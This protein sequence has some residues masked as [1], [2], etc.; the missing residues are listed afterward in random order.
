MRY[1]LRHALRLMLRRPGVAALVVTTLAIGI[2]AT[3]VVFSLAD[4]ILWHP[5]P[6]SDAERFVRVRVAF[7]APPSSGAPLDLDS[8]LFDGVYP[9]QLNSAIVKVAGE[10]RAVT[11]GEI[12]QGLVHTLGAL[13]M[14]G[15]E[16]APDEFVADSRVVIVSA[17]LW[18]QQRAAKSPDDHTLSIDGVSHTIVGVMPD[19]FEFPVSRV[20][21]WRPLVPD[22]S[23]AR[24]TGL[25]RLKPGVT[26]G[27]AQAFAQAARTTRGSP[28]SDIR[29]VPFVFVIPSTATALRILLGAVALLLLIAVANAANIIQAETVRRDTELAVRAS[30]GAS[31]LRLVRQLITEA[32]LISI[33][34]A[35]VAVVVSAWTLAAL[36]KAVPYLMSFQALRPIG[37]DWRALVFA[38]G[39]SLVAGIGASWLSAIRARR[40]DPQMALRGH[41]SG[42]PGQARAREI[43]TAA[44][45][46]VTLILLCGAGLL[47]NGFLRLSRVDP[48]FDPSHLI[49]VE[50]QLPTWRYSGEPDMR[51]ALDRLRTETMRLPGVEGV[52]IAHSM[53][54]NLES[55]PL[56]GLVTDDTTLAP[57]TGYVSTG[58]VDDRFF[59]TLG[60][61][62]LAGRAFD[63]RDQQNSPPVAVVSR[64]FAQQLWPGR[65]PLGR[66][67]RESATTLWHTIVGIVGDV[68]N[69]GFDQP[70]GP[71]AY[72]TARNQSPTWWYEGLI[73]RTRSTPERMVP[74]L[75]SVI[76]RA[77]P[78]APVV[79]V[80]TGYDTIAGANARVRFA[81][82]LMITFAAI[83]LAV[84]LIGIYGT[85]WC[86]VSQR[87]REIG[88][89]MALGATSPDVLRMVLAGSI[90]LVA[91]GLALGLPLSLATSQV[92]KSLLFEVSPT[93]PTTFVAVIAFLAAAAMA[94]TFFPA[95]RAAAVD[96]VE[97]LRTQ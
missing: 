62:L 11:V 57:N 45:I 72:Y 21:L 49:D 76:Q 19:G 46:A 38:T 51:A 25:G 85:F 7:V 68:R 58:I 15:R 93:D 94:A 30:L 12:S 71:L 39:I 8:S 40:M 3:T 82:L 31:W 91:I 88:V 29:I 4:A 75:R 90:R 77:L 64:A 44:Q 70:L 37:M 34:A 63:D 95:R 22:A 74:A 61:P 1:D 35:V 96:P 67:F 84:A 65:D 43:L 86:T 53:P 81:T 42:V 41:A 32:L 56:D 17:G 33:I 36:V 54:P 24:M 73:V 79:G 20:A 23:A 50:V 10:A 83:A 27:Q 80:N 6:F 87:T 89:R 18:R 92:L 97:A 28:F 52:T 69:G 78:D 9:F 16:F 47:G 5:L 55:R 2:A 13:P 48:G 60:I 59:A 26:I 66:R 14:W